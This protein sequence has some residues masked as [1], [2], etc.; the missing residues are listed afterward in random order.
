MNSSRPRW[1]GGPKPV[2]RVPRTTKRAPIPLNVPIGCCTIC[3]KNI[4]A[5]SGEPRPYPKSWPTELQ[6]YYKEEGKDIAHRKCLQRIQQLRTEY[7]SGSIN[8]RWTKGP[9]LGSP[10]SKLQARQNRRRSKAKTRS[11]IDKPFTSVVR[12]PPTSS[13][14]TVIS[15]PSDSLHKKT[16]VIAT[17]PAPP[18]PFQHR[19]KLF[20]DST[21]T[22]KSPSTFPQLQISNERSTSGKK[23][24]RN[25]RRKLKVRVVLVDDT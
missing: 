16:K 21:L 24:G 25:G 5:V 2:R 13:L 17:P 1:G 18:I 10:R 11:S 15:R 12:P 23:S 4:L 19:N 6:I 9:P 7:V 3:G 8:E 22:S 20:H 14:G